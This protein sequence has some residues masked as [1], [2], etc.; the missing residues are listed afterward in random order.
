MP[1]IP[2]REH[3]GAGVMSHPRLVAALAGS[4]DVGD[5]ESRADDLAVIVEDVLASA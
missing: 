2:M 5:P 3:R 1:H 4:V